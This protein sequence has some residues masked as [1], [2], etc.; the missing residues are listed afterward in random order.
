MAASGAN[1]AFCDL[2]SQAGEA[3]EQTLQKDHPNQK[4]NVGQTRRF[5]GWP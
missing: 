1:V 4:F 2:N 5:L 3:F